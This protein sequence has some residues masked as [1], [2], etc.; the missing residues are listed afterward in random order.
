MTDPIKMTPKLTAQWQLVQDAMQRLVHWWTL[1]LN[2]MVY[3]PRK[4]DVDGEVKQSKDI[5]DQLAKDLH[6]VEAKHPHDPDAA[7]GVLAALMPKE[8]K[9]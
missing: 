4:F 7:A 9:S 1:E 3:V 5:L 6:A 2:T 8:P